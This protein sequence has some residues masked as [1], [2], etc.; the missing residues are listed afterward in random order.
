MFKQLTEAQFQEMR[1]VLDQYPLVTLD[2]WSIANVQGPLIYAI[3]SRGT[4]IVRLSSIGQDGR[5]YNP[6]LCTLHEDNGGYLFC[7][8]N[9]RHVKL[10]RLMAATW[11]AD[12]DE[13]LTVNHRDG[14]KHNNDYHNLEMMTVHDNCVY[15]HTA[16]CISDQRKQDYAHHGDT[17][18]GRI[19]ITNGVKAR[20]IYES[21]GI[22]EGWWRGRP[23]TMRD[24]LSMTSKGRRSNKLGKITITDG[25]SNRWIDP[26]ET[27]PAGWTK[28]FTMALSPQQSRVRSD[29]VKGTIYVTKET[30]NKRIH[31]DELDFYIEEGWKIGMYSKRWNNR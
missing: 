21:D 14:N 22:P 18:R 16:E 13:T 28:G 8:L 3:N 23:Q 11:L 10:H 7:S 6:K 17:L 26:S 31:P 25:Q 4:I 9:N 1:S 5:L 24:K 30:V 27:V 19:H 2:E 20:M 29:R 15:Y 12:W